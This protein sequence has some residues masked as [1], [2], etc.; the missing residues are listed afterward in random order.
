[1]RFPLSLPRILSSLAFATTMI[2]GASA[3]EKE[4]EDHESPF[5]D[6]HQGVVFT[7]I[8]ASS[9]ELHVSSGV[10]GALFSKREE[11]GWRLLF[12]TGQKFRERDPLVV[13]RFNRF[14]A[15]R[16]LVGHEWQRD[17]LAI[18]AMAGASLSIL[19]PWE[20]AFT[21]YQARLGVTGLLEFWKNWTP[22][23]PMP[24]GFSSLTLIADAGES[25]AY[26]RL[27]HGF[28]TGFR[29]LALGPE[30]A[31]ST[32]GRRYFGPI[33]LRDSWLKAR[34]GLHAT[35]LMI[36]RFGVNVSGG[37]EFRSRQRGSPYGELTALW[38]Y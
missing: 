31:L 23:G 24:A 36:G 7:G 17:G 8:S 11:P 32:G 16:L 10:K 28:S 34:L 13:G 18:T 21:G 29:S 19:S 4:P 38:N 30:F 35:G 5:R 9:W 2:V 1:M 26:L 20:Q 22:D 15:A 6:R 27:R 12:T 3:A 14:D 33:V 37:Y 25:S